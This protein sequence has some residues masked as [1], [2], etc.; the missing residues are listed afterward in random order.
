MAE[1]AGLT[2]DMQG[3]EA[4]MEAARERSKA[5]GKKVCWCGCSACGGAVAKDTA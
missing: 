2:V 4:A 1:E 5:A 3:F